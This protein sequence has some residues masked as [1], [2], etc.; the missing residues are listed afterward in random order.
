LEIFN[1]DSATPFVPEV[2]YFDKTSIR[3][4]EAITYD[5]SV[6]DTGVTGYW[7]VHT[8][9]EIVTASVQNGLSLQ[10]LEEHSHLNR[11]V[12]YAMYENQ[13]A[14]ILMCYT[15]VARAVWP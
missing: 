6:D 2:S 11:E 8:L 12:D 7:F 3:I 9:G 13:S 15:L 4:E 10:H 14:Q 1:P 5:G